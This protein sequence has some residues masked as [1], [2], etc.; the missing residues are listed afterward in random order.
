MD[1]GVSISMSEDIFAN[2]HDPS[3]HFVVGK[4]LDIFYGSVILDDT[5][6][7]VYTKAWANQFL[8]KSSLEYDR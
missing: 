3:G 8:T 5:R 6:M 1:Y 4:S 2:M 7:L